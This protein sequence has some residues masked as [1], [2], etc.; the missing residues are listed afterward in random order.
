MH[1]HLGGECPHQCTYCYVGRMPWGKIAK[2]TG[3]VHL[4][5]KELEV[6]YGEGR[7]IF[8]E[9][10]NDMFAASVPDA[11]IRQILEH[12]CRYPKNRYLF[13]T[14]NPARYADY[15]AAMPPDFVLGATAETNRPTAGISVA[16]APLDRLAAMGGYT[17]KKLITVEPVL[18]FDLDPFVA[19]LLAAK[20][21]HVIVGAD[22]KFRGLKEP[23][24]TD[25]LALLAALRAAGLDVVQKPNLARLLR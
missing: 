17:A 25:L 6:N 21:D 19:A 22:S 8:V 13:H 24:K 4:V 3:A 9:H 5:A 2:Y 20:P 14:K 7:R 15:I 18:E 1:T 12:C 23:S 16:P 11:M 10:C